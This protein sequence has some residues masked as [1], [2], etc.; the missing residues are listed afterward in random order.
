MIGLALWLAFTAQAGIPA[1][2]TAVT[3]A[4]P[5]AAG[6]AAAPMD[7][8]CDE[9]VLL[10][11]SGPIRDAARMQAYA[12]TQAASGLYRQNGGYELS[13]PRPADVLEGTVHFTTIVRFP[14]RTNALLFWHSQTYQDQLRALRVNPAASDLSAAIYPEAALRPD[15][16]GKV[17][18]NTYTAAFEASS[19]VLTPAGKP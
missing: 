11:I 9:P 10:V 3:P 1:I 13:A 19:V 16:V 14:C 7:D 6:R 5:L 4:K 18:D 8:T 15:M 2:D 12:Q 17:G